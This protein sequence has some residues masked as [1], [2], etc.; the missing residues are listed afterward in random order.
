MNIQPAVNNTG[1][2]I[3]INWNKS[4]VIKHGYVTGKHYATYNDLE[5]TQFNWWLKRSEIVKEYH[6]K[7]TLAL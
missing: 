2:T 1:D 4:K 5:C 6:L 7:G 3:Y